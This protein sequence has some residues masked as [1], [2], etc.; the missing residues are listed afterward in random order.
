MT[1]IRL[2]LVAFVMI[3]FVATSLFPT[4]AEAAKILYIGGTMSLTG[5]TLRIPQRF[6]PPM[7]TMLNM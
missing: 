1:K 5:A 4:S 7:R 6:W 3:M 2:A